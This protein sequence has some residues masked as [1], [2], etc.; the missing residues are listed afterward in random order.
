M[1]FVSESMSCSS[2]LCR[3]RPRHPRHSRIEVSHPRAPY[4]ADDVSFK[5]RTATLVTKFSLVLSG[6]LQEIFHIY[7]NLLYITVQSIFEVLHVPSCILGILAL[8]LYIRKQDT[9]LRSLLTNVHE[10][11]LSTLLGGFMAH[12]SPISEMFRHAPHNSRFSLGLFDE[13]AF[14]AIG[15][16]QNNAHEMLTTYLLSRVEGRIDRWISVVITL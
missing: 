3:S 10:R 8:A 7:C 5:D 14:R 15:A 1:L 11:S 12:H 6:S 16:D 9:D 13:Q 4:I 2:K